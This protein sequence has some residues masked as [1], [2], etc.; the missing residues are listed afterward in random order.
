MFSEDGEE[1]FRHEGESIQ[2]R[3]QQMS[4]LCGSVQQRE[5]SSNVVLDSRAVKTWWITFSVYPL[6]PDAS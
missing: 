4:G 2:V 3:E 6:P 1:F 5:E